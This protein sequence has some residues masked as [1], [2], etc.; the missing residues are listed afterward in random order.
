MTAESEMVSDERLGLLDALIYADVFDCAVTLD[1][2]WRYGRVAIGRDAL[3]QR[4]RD[5]P[6]LSRIV[7]ARDALYC[8]A[9]RPGLL[10]ERPPRI[11]RARA[12]QR[13]AC[14]VARVLRHVPFVRALAL[15]GSVAA[16][17]AREAA[18]VDLLVVVAPARL[19]IA[20]LLLAPASRL[21]GR[22]LFCPNY[23]ICEDQLKLAPSTLYVARELAQ[24]RSLVGDIRVLH[25]PNPWLG[26][27]FPN[28]VTSLDDDHALR[29]GTRLQRLLERPLSGRRADRL[30]R[31]ARRVAL[32]RLRVHYGAFGR[33]VPADVMASLDAGIELRF[34]G[35]PYDETTVGRYAARRAQVAEWLRDAERIA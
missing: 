20:F 6:S 8:L 29:P 19:G 4:L 22:R 11:E 1:E 13:R 12:L 16:D 34:H 21:L 17:D 15:T 23:Y 31:W 32:A 18:D 27:V 33:G 10:D 24:A 30:E 28:G 35:Q 7:R 2:L 5:D 9:D 25:V 3:R 14:R 26:D